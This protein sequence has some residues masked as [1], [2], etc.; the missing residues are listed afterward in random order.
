MKSTDHL[1]PDFNQISWPVKILRL[2]E[3]THQIF[4]FKVF[5]DHPHSISYL[6]IAKYPQENVLK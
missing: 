1:N 5:Q 2:H 3:D 4:V 6:P